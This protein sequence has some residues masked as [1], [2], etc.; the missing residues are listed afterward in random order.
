MCSFRVIIKLINGSLDD[1]EGNIPINE[2]LSIGDWM[3]SNSGHKRIRAIIDSIDFKLC[4]SKLAYLENLFNKLL[5]A[6][7]SKNKSDM[8]IEVQQIMAKQE[9]IA[10]FYEQFYSM[11]FEATAF[12]YFSIHHDIDDHIFEP[13]IKII[14]QHDLINVDKKIVYNSV[15]H[16]I[17]LH[18][19]NFGM[20]TS[21]WSDHY[22]LSVDGMNLIISSMIKFGGVGINDIISICRCMLYDYRQKAEM[23]LKW[24]NENI[25]KRM[26]SFQSLLP[27][28][29]EN[30]YEPANQIFRDQ[31]VINC[32]KELRKAIL[33]CYDS[34]YCFQKTVE[35]ADIVFDENVVDSV[36]LRC[37][38]DN[39]DKFS[40][41]IRIFI[42]KI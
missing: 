18:L 22:R 12:N 9:Q 7:L 39:D 8:M 42:E 32:I 11:I 20:R 15:K 41:D 13:I 23:A 24:M 29:Y 27:V 28:N 3:T 37:V 25:V 17:Q 2:F 40:E 14:L 36:I 19:P 35:E 1:L 31:I 26:A 30:N 6:K 38:Y 34:H 10:W 21:F 4:F 33:T 16:R 5:E